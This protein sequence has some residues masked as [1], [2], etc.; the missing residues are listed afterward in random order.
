M[1]E[2][3]RGH[4]AALLVQYEKTRHIGNLRRLCLSLPRYYWSIFRHRVAAA[5]RG[6]LKSEIRGCFRGILFYLCNK[7]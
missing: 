5:A 4:V 6:T 1:E 2:Y 3:M 7:G